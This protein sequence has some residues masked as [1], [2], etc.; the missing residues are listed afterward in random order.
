MPRG[1][2]EQ[3]LEP[4]HADQLRELRAGGLSCTPTTF[5]PTGYPATASSAAAVAAE[6]SGASSAAQAAQAGRKVSFWF[7]TKTRITTGTAQ[8]VVPSMISKLPLVR[9]VLAPPERVLVEELHAPDRQRRH[10]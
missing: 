4:E 8:T 6:G 9:L 7:F 2:P 5:Y 3:Y 1:V 10:L